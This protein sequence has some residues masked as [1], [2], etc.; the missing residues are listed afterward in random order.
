MN[1]FL[2]VLLV[3]VMTLSGTFGAIFF[4]K[5]SAAIDRTHLLRML[6][7]PN[8]Y[9]GGFFYVLGAVLNI[10][11]L[12]YMDYSVLYPMTSLTYIWT[13]IVSYL[14]F[15]EKINAYKISALCCIVLGIVILNI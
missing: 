12:R 15:K 1:A 5:A 2:I 14:V 9:I 7:N 10:I 3:V 6:V 4:K 8:L 11:L 13:M